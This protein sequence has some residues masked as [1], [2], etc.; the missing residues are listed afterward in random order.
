[1]ST[2]TL[3]TSHFIFVPWH[4]SPIFVLSL[5]LGSKDGITVVSIDFIVVEWPLQK[6][7]RT[8]KLSS[9]AIVCVTPPDSSSCSNTSSMGWRLAGVINLGWVSPG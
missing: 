1:M 2:V 9:S 6:I 4:M 7:S 8:I 5:C 3:R